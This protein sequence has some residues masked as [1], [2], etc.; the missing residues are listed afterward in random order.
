MQRNVGSQNSPPVPHCTWPFHLILGYNF[1]PCFHDLLPL[2]GKQPPPHRNEEACIKVNPVFP[3]VNLE[4]AIGELL[5][6]AREV[7]HEYVT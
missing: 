6:Q 3:A 5:F 4:E 2:Q 7:F 1:G